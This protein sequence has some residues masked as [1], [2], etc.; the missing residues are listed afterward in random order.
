MNNK[1]IRKRIRL[2]ITRL[3]SIIFAIMLVVS[4]FTGISVLA[5]QNAFK[6]D[7]ATIT[8]KSDTVTGDINKV[9]NDKVKDN[10]TFHRVNDDVTYKLVIK[11]NLDKEITI[12]SITDD[13]DN[14]YIT[15]EY[16][17]HN[18]E[19]LG[20]GD[21][22]DFLVTTRY[23][24]SVTDMSKRDQNISTN[25]IINYLLDGEEQ[26]D[27]I[28]DNPATGDNITWSFIIFIISSTGL[29]I[30]IALDRRNSHKKLSKT[31]MMGIVGL[32]LT[33]FV[34][35]AA[36]LTY[37]IE[38][39]SN[40]GLYDKQVVTYTINGEEKILINQYGEAI[41]GLEAPEEAGYTFEKW[42]YEDGTDFDPT[43]D[44][45]YF[46]DIND[47]DPREEDYD[48]GAYMHVDDYN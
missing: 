25:F 39:E 23:N 37:K 36:T 19:K 11:N 29:I 12:L 1:T 41:S 46:D 13:N 42:V 44:C 20:A 33:P 16:D 47:D 26:S 43:K 22:F 28:N 3:F 2:R 18:N 30:C 24:S 9:S 10:V 27:S 8:D 15:Y 48:C 45:Y 5:E 21:S 34:V 7:T 6:L 31:A 40:Y 32:M 4:L 35:K 14:D 38:L 17:K